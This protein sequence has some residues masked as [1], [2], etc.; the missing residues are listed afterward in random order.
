M[1]TKLKFIY[2]EKKYQTCITLDA[3]CIN[4]DVGDTK[5]TEIY[6]VSYNYFSIYIKYF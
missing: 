3:D 5:Y 1:Y 2:C 4:R 6:L